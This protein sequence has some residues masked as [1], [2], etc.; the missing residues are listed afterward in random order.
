VKDNNER[1]VYT[2]MIYLNEGF[3]GGETVFYGTKQVQ[4]DLLQI[5][6]STGTALVFR[7]DVE[8]AGLPIIDV[9]PLS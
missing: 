3:A 4:A 2:V 6:P 7:Q 9:S 5:H 1:S 8:H